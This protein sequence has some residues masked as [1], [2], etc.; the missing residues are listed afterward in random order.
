METGNATGT[1]NFG[2]GDFTA[3]SIAK[4]VAGYAAFNWQGGTLHVGTFG[5]PSIH[6]DLANTG[7]GMLAPANT[8]GT[9]PGT[10]QIFGN[11]TQQSSA[12]MQID[13]G[14]RARNGLRPGNDQQHRKPG[15]HAGRAPDQR[16][17]ADLERNLHDHSFGSHVGN[18][19]SFTGLD[20]GNHLTLQPLMTATGLELIARPTL[21]GDINLDG[22]VK[23]QDLAAVSSTWLSNSPQG[24]VNADGIVNSQDLA[25]ISA[26]WLAADPSAGASAMQLSAVPEPASYV[27]LLAGALITLGMRFNRRDGLS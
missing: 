14:V 3:A 15:G 23:A 6:L 12:T 4:G 22:I 5:T 9:V 16:L 24:D 26:N 27:L 18:F 19:S 17:S 2:G 25:V 8:A 1:I 7:T 11:Y 21:N 20:V 10:T 13:L